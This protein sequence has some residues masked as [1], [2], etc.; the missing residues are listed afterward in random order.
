[1][2]KR[3]PRW[4]IVLISAVVMAALVALN[5]F[6]VREVI[7]VVATGD[8]PIRLKGQRKD[9]I[10]I[11][12]AGQSAGTIEGSNFRVVGRAATVSENL[13]GIGTA[14]CWNLL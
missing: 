8:S 7:Q 13:S 10:V 14:S 5:F 6:S 9:A 3:I 2:F 12:R 1:M 4:P 11:L